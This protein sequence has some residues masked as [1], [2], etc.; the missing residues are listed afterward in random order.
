MNG[1][2]VYFI[3]LSNKSRAADYI[4]N[5]QAEAEQKQFNYLLFKTANTVLNYDKYKLA[6]SQ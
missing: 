3:F 2:D 1:L 5:S 6:C 4:Y